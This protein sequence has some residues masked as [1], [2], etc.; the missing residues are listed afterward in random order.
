ML[1]ED[2]NVY[3]SALLQLDKEF[4]DLLTAATAV[5]PEQASALEHSLRRVRGDDTTGDDE[6]PGSLDFGSAIG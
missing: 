5:D 6:Q 3:R 4:A 2:E 1:R